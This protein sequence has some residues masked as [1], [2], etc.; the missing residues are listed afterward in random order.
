[1]SRPILI[2]AGIVIGDRIIATVILDRLL[3]HVVTL[4]GRGN[5]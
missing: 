3:H 2:L 1:M 5:S 4:N